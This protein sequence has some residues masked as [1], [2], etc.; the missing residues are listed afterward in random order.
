[1]I[2]LSFCSCSEDVYYMIWLA[3]CPPHAAA[4]VPLLHYIRQTFFVFL[5]SLSSQI[6]LN[7]K[8]KSLGRYGLKHWMHKY[9]A[10]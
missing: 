8:L 9:M 1:M 3:G 5:A 10:T 4:A 6:M 7:L 2:H